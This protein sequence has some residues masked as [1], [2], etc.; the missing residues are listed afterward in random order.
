MKDAVAEADWDNGGKLISR[1]DTK[2][3]QEAAKAQVPAVDGV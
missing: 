3:R 2:G 1:E